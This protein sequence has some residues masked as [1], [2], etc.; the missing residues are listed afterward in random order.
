MGD[1]SAGRRA[2]VSSWPPATRRFCLSFVL[3]RAVADGAKDFSNAECRRLQQRNEQ[4]Y[5]FKRLSS[6]GSR[7]AQAGNDAPVGASNRNSRANDADCKLGVLGCV[8]LFASLLHFLA[9]ALGVNNCVRSNGFGNI[10]VPDLHALDAAIK[11]IESVGVPTIQKHVTELGDRLLSRLDELG[12]GVVG[13]R[14]RDQRNHIYVLTLPV[15][16]WADYFARNDVRVSAERCG[17][18]VSLAMFNTV[19][20]VDRLVELI[21]VGQREDAQA[22]TTQI[23]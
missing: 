16:K 23:D 15:A 11:L 20:D 14:G 22:F 17:I 6:L 8:A 18:R 10:N 9:Q 12:V 5:F 7:D 1:R 13:P 19:E 2:G 4:R 21:R 3:I